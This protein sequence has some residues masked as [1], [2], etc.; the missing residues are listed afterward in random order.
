M[1]RGFSFPCWP[2]RPVCHHPPGF[3]FPAAGDGTEFDLR[4]YRGRFPL[5]YLEVVGRG[6]AGDHM[7]SA[8][9]VAS[10]ALR[11]AKAGWPGP[12][13]GIPGSFRQCETEFRAG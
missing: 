4:K 7:A 8:P 3:K 13:P 10:V 6:A 12:A 11:A 2:V 9:Q 5:I 1:Q